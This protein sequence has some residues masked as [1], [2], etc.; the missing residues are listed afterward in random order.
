MP[1][2]LSRKYR[3]ECLN[4][5]FPLPVLC[6][7]WDTVWSSKKLYSIK[8]RYNHKLMDIMIHIKYSI[9][10]L[11][12]KEISDRCSAS[13]TPNLLLLD[14]TS[15]SFKSSFKTSVTGPHW[16]AQSAEKCTTDKVGDLEVIKLF[17]IQYI[18]IQNNLNTNNLILLLTY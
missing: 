14:W 4:I 5:K 6:Y 7:M 10:T 15:G 1:G 16:S 12:F 9:H 17:W 2:K 18:L 11:Y 3:M 13:H 8:M